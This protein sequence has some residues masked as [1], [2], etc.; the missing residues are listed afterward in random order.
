MP[1]RK[2]DRLYLIHYSGRQRIL[3]THYLTTPAH[4]L[5]AEALLGET[6]RLRTQREHSL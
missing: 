2:S 4:L 5:C 3:E 6:V 1:H